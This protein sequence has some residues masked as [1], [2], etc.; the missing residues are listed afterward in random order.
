MRLIF[1]LLFLFAASSSVSA[2]NSLQDSCRRP[3]SFAYLADIHIAENTNRIDDAITCVNDINNQSQIK[4]VIIAGDIT[5]FGADEEI[6]IAKTIWHYIGARLF[7]DLI[8]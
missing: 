1:T 8:I 2:Q 6:K 4:F 3:F 5:E 7:L